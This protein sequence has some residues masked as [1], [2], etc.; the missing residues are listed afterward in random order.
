MEVYLRHQIEEQFGKKIETRG[1]C[2]TLSDL[3]SEHTGVLLSY[4]TIRRFFGLDKNKY[5]TRASTLDA[6]SKYL[7]Y[8]SFQHFK[9]SL[10]YDQQR[11][12][13]L[14]FY[15]LLSTHNPD[16]IFPLL[17]ANRYNKPLFIELIIHTTRHFIVHQQIQALLDLLDD[18]LRLHKKDYS[19]DEMLYLGNAIGI[20]L[21]SNQLPKH[22]YISLQKSMFFNAFI[23]EMFVDY[24]SLN[25]HYQHFI[26]AKALNDE[27]KLFKSC[28]K[29]LH[30]FLNNK[31]IAIVQPISKVDYKLL[32]PLL[33]GRLASINLYSQQPVLSKKF[34]SCVHI[35]Q[36][37]FFYEPMVASMVT[38]DFQLFDLIH[39]KLKHRFENLSFHQ[40]HYFHVYLLFKATYYFK[41]GLQQEARTQLEGFDLQLI[42]LS[43]KDLLHFYYSLLDWRLN[44][45]ATSKDH[46]M[47]LARLLQYER[48]DQHY[49]DNY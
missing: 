47:Q 38:S 34:K 23:F 33:A 14:H 9:T 37:E 12:S 44:A 27:Q 25:S 48:F 11:N 36:L 16:R 3:I 22:H 6:L 20:V 4:N 2:E 1:D 45:N 10:P 15:E 35:N 43:Y 17:V 19:L 40:L 7:S 32:S 5:R 31:P 30:A 46:A 29:R 13:S 49:I 26:Y 39:S 42:R 8:D 18:R 41:C 21:R 24:S 28:L